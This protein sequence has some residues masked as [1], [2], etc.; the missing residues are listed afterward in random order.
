MVAGSVNTVHGLPPEAREHPRRASGLG[1]RPGVRRRDLAVPNVLVGRRPVSRRRFLELLAGMGVGAAVLPLAA[2][3]DDG[4]GGGDGASGAA[5][6]SVPSA[7]PAPEGYRP[8]WPD[9][10]IAGDPLPDG[11]VVWTRLEAP[12]DGGEVGVLWEVAADEAFATV[13]AGGVVPAT[14]EGDH[15]AKVRVEGLEPDRWYWYRFTVGD[16]SSPVGRL[17][18]APGPDATP[19]RLRFAFASCQQRGSSLYVAHRAAAAEPDLAFFLHLGDYVYVSDD[20]DLTL[21]DYRARYHE[22]KADPLLQQLQATVPLVAMYDDGEF[23]NG[24][25][26]T[27]D[28][29]RLA[30]ARQA[31]FET[32]PVV[33]GP[34]DIAYRALRWGTLADVPVIDTRAYRDPAIE[35]SDTRTPEGAEMLAPGRT[36]L[37]ATQKQWL[38]DLLRTSTADW[39]LLGST[40]DLAAWRL[41]PDV[42]V[43]NEAWDDYWAERAELFGLLA[44]EGIDNVVCCS[45]H[46]HVWIASHLPRDAADPTS[47]NVGFDFTVGSLTADPDLLDGLEGAERQQERE[48]YR[49]LEAASLE[50]NPWQTYLNLVDQGYAVVDVT[51]EETVVE[52]K[53]IDPFDE[54]AEARVG[55]RFT[56]ASGATEMRTERFADAER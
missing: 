30:A 10:V 19:D 11:A 35:P 36:T 9:G 48:R 25:D 49:A 40:Y 53:L 16:T 54:A 18:T 17:R 6:T 12:G 31:W 22:F 47:P 7:P 4:G 2:C 46:T 42:Y 29:A 37:G 38:F 13:A 43:P 1:Y 55:A 52:F 51:P 45:G 32:M 5:T 41:G 15:T 56:V 39:R 26:A 3:S 34:D 20:G 44:D 24:V 28:P 50:A 33:P 14:A 27:G 23:Y 8:A 21:A